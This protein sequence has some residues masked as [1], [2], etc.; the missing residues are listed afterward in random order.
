MANCSKYH[1]IQMSATLLKHVTGDL[2]KLVFLPRDMK[3]SK[4]K[5]G[6]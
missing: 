6:W 3:C 1:E 2:K 4:I 5:Q